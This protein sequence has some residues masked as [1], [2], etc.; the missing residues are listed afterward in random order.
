[1][2]IETIA[3]T[4]MQA[5]M[6]NMEVISNNIANSNTL[7]F[8]KSYANFSDLFPSGNSSAGAQAGLGVSVN[9]I[10]QDFTS[11]GIQTT[12]QIL[13]LSIKNSS[14]FI[15]KDPATG[16]TSYS[17]AGRFDMDNNGYIVHGNDRVQGFQ[18][19]NGA[20][21]SPTDLQISKTPMPAKAST[22]AS[23]SINLDSNAK[24]PANVFSDS[25]P[26]SYNFAT[27]T[28]IYDSLGN[29]SKLTLYYVKSATDNTWVVNTEVN[30]TAS[31]IGT[32]TFSQGGIL[33]STTG[34]SALT[35]SPTTGATSPQTISVNLAESTQYG[36]NG[37]QALEA[38]TAD[39]YQSGMLSGISVD[40]NGIISAQYTN[41]Q[42]MP[43]GQLALAQFQSPEGLTSIGN[44]S[45]TANAASGTPIINASNSS[46]NFYTGAVELSN[47]D[48]T[49]EMVN[50][51][52]AQH[53]FQANAQVEQTYNEVMQTIIKL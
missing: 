41:Q 32:M 5:A 37:S 18:T 34:L 48:L 35:Y 12:G 8:K 15:M 16:V 4:G 42:K 1:M 14:F 20:V 24:A 50:L 17:R 40:L 51:I 44:S 52:G 33:T 2:G 26:A 21:V 22:T 23:G 53:S 28:T 3:I 10:Q 49:Q 11:G 27:N 19:V 30:G 25:D 45:W 31:G 47:V 13:D 36:G 43:A 29:P 38:F 39:G 7:G 6:S 46:G 9:N